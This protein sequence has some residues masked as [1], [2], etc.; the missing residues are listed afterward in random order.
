MELQILQQLKL[1]LEVKGLYSLPEEWKASDEK[2]PAL[3]N[4]I[5]RLQNVK[6]SN[7]RYQQRQLTEQ[8]IKEQE[9]LMNKNKKA[10]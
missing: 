6:V 1:K 8:E 5:V 9:E 4:Y 10:P 7:G 3:F 2:D